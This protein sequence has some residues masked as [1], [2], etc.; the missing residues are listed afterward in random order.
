M[1]SFRLQLRRQ[2]TNDPKSLLNQKQNKV[3][4][5]NE[6]Q[7]PVPTPSQEVDPLATPGDQVKIEYPLIAADI[8]DNFEMLMGTKEVK[9][10]GESLN[11]LIRTTR[12][13]V[14]CNG[15]YKGKTLN[16]GHIIRQSIWL[17]PSGGL[18]VDMIKVACKK[19]NDAFGNYLASARDLINNPGMYDGKVF[20]GKTR[21]AVDKKGNFPDKNEVNFVAAKKG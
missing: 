20:L 14:A 17:T 15:D 9:P 5:M 12:D 4:Q 8:M 19:V 16:T 21:I 11:F 6:T 3:K 10:N 18:T 7:I 1:K 13:H 2:R